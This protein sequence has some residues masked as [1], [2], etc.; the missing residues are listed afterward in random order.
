M[1]DKKA[2]STPLPTRKRGPPGMVTPNLFSAA[3]RRRMSLADED[4]DFEQSLGRELGHTSKVD[5][6]SNRACLC[7]GCPCG[8]TVRFRVWW[9]W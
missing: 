9:R 3:K 5:V 4:R 8:R 2:P 1:D 6:V 7:L